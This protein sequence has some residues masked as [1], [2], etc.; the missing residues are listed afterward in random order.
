MS[1][2]LPAERRERQ[3][4]E[5]PRVVGVKRIAGDASLLE[6]AVVARAG[7]VGGIARED[8]RLVAVL[9]VAA[10]DPLKL[11]RSCNQDAR[12]RARSS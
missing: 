6:R 10:P 2:A 3:L 9:E 1:C 12:G 5:P 11:G 7:L 8:R 4:P